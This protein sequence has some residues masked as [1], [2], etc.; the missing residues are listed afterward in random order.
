MWEGGELCLFGDLRVHGVVWKEVFFGHAWFL[1]ADLCDVLARYLLYR[2]ITF[3]D[4]KSYCSHSMVT[5][6]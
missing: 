4:E 2:V 3:S 5:G 1:A 6:N